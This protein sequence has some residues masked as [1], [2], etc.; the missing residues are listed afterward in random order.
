MNQFSFQHL[1]FQCKRFQI[2]H[3]LRSCLCLCGI[4]L[5]CFYTLILHSHTNTHTSLSCWCRIDIPRYTCSFIFTHF[6]LFLMSVAI[7][8][9]I[10]LCNS[11][12]LALD[13]LLFFHLPQI[14]C[15][16]TSLHFSLNCSLAWKSLKIIFSFSSQFRVHIYA[17][18]L[19]CF[20]IELDY[21]VYFFSFNLRYLT[22]T[23]S[24]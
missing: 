19:P 17:Q 6:Y 12:A 9:T 7:L 4:V 21:H 24:M 11:W 2:L 10:L 15:L 14:W 1:Q 23:S 5:L 16:S 18:L 3:E 13:G 20:L 8:K 22:S